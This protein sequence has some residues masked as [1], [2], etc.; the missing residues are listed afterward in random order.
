MTQGLVT[1]KSGQKVLMKVVAGSD[2][3]NAKKLADWLRDFWPKSPKQVYKKALKLEFGCDSCLVVITD[4]QVFFE[5][6]C[7]DSNS[8][9]ADNPLYRKTFQQ[10]EFN[11]RW[12]NGIAEYLE[13]VEV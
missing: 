1:V 7:C 3:N 4:S 13:I 10:P 11:P 12:E 5:G 6:K 8:F 2:G 9:D